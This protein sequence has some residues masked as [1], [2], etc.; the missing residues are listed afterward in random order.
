MLEIL[1][2]T[3]IIV[4]PFEHRVDGDEAIIANASRSSFLSV[5]VAALGLLADLAAGRTIGQAQAAYAQKYGETPDVEEFLDLLAS[6]GFISRTPPDDGGVA[7]ANLDRVVQPAKP[8]RGYHFEWITEQTARRI[9]SW[10]VLLPAIGL[11]LV[12]LVAVAREPALLPSPDVMVF[13]HDLTPLTLAMA[14]FILATIFLHELAHLVAARSAGA[15]AR[16]GLSN[17]LWYLVAETDLTGVWLAS[18]R[19][20]YVAFL[21]GPLLDTTGAAILVLLLWTHGH[22]HWLPPLADELGQIFLFTYIVRL[23][24]QCYFFVRTDFYYV[25]AAA[26]SCKNLLGDT[27]NWLRNQLARL[28]PRVSVVDQSAIPE[29]ELKVIRAY[30]VIWLLGRGVAFVMLV[31]FGLPILWGYCCELITIFLGGQASFYSFVDALV[32]CGLSVAIQGS[33][34]LLWLR[35]IYRAYA[36]R[37]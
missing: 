1:A 36:R 16:L 22:W 18:R 21:A 34:M 6:E 27:E 26:F 8:I 5:P 2:D 29:A 19:R 13:Q 31:C 7:V 14:G 30:A 3:R 17:R 28:F 9:C 37:G 35:G 10:P 32:W 33:G 24:W 20:R 23:L 12:A 4:H 15:P 11:Q 25:I